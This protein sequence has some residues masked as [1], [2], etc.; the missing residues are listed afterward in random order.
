[1]SAEEPSETDAPFDLLGSA[2]VLG[3]YVWVERR[4]H[5]LLGAWSADADRPDAAVL[6]DAQALHHAWYADVF[7]D[8]LP[9]LREVP[10]ERVVTAPPGVADHLEGLAGLTGTVERLAA[11]VDVELPALVS[12]YR[13]HLDRLTPVAD[14][15]LQRWLRI[16]LGDLERDLVDATAVLAE[17][18]AERA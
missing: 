6:L 9:Q 11:L 12:T 17:T 8:R 1:M 7:L 5:Q 10:V 13:A 15:P 16:V 4:L 18:A 3:G 2:R 14:A